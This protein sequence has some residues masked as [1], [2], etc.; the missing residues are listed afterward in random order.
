[1]ESVTVSMTLVE[2]PDVLVVSPSLTFQLLSLIQYVI[3]SL[4]LNHA[5]TATVE[6]ASSLSHSLLVAGLAQA[7]EKAVQAATMPRMTE[8]A[9]ILI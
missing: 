5:M 8:Y 7:E 9:F 2:T 3:V 6:S 1:M 4:L